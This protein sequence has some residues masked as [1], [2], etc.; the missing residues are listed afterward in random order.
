M[1]VLSF[2]FKKQCLCKGQLTFWKES[3]G[4]KSELSEARLLRFKAQ[5]SHLWV[6]G[7]WHITETLV[8]EFARL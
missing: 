8:P 4:R 7:L 1:V 2:P 5:L 6:V 3:S